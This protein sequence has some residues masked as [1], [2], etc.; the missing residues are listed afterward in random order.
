[1]KNAA[2]KFFASVLLI[3]VTYVKAQTTNHF[4]IFPTIDHSGTLSDKWDYSLYY[5]GAVNVFNPDIG[6]IK[7]PSGF[8]IFYSEQA[9]SYKANK[10][11]SLTGSYVY[12][13]TDPAENYF[14]NENRFYFQ[15][16]YKTNRNRMSFKN[17]LR[18]DGRFIQD[19]LTGN[20]PFTSRVRYLFGLQTPL[21]KEKDNLYLTAYNE[22]FFN[23]C[24]NSAVI[25]GENWASAALGFKTAKAGN[26]E[27]GPLYIFWVINKQY[28][29]TNLLYLQLT[30]STH[31]NF[32]KNK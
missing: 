3:Y 14:V 11:L 8:F 25:Y 15:A 20:Y 24:K 32:K 13:R 7:R 2:V 17:R 18:Y 29:L 26:W 9:L 12:Q 19:K 30:W 22:F 4:G 23:T 10:N 6:P 5:F 28:D 16:T 27:I 21:K 31:L 1:M